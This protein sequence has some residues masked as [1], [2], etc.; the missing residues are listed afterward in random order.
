MKRGAFWG[1]GQIVRYNLPMYAL[2]AVVILAVGLALAW[3]PMPRWLALLLTIAGGAALFWTLA[4]LAV[5]HWIYDRSKLRHWAWIVGLLPNLPLRWAS[6]H[7]GL[8]E[9]DGALKRFLVAGQGVVLDF[10]DPAEMTEPSIHRARRI[11]L[12]R[13]A[14]PADF[15]HLPLPDAS[16]DAVFLVFAA[17]ELRRPEARVALF[18]ELSRALM[19]RGRAVLVEHTRDAASFLAFGPGFLHFLPKREWLRLAEASGLRVTEELRITPFVTA[20]SLEKAG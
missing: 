18:R 3:L 2:S 20:F 10:F 8:D 16:Q 1:V 19:P 17:H 15:R 4:S 6:L 11:A 13:S 14:K 5:S 9:T 12:D 7:A